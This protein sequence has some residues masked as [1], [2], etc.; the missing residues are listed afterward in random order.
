MAGIGTAHTRLDG[1]AKVTGQAHYGS[2]APFAKPAY[3]CLATSAI[4][5]GRIAAIDERETRAV[6]GVIDVFTYH[7]IGKIEAG[8]TF[9]EGGYVGS[10]I[11]PL[12]S[13]EIFHDGQIV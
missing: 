6:P 3:A 11:A 5:R 8:K 12:A 13:A 2:D 9:D 7:N 1:H 4:A 10:T